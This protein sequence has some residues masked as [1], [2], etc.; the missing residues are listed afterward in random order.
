MA[1]GC[2]CPECWGLAE[3]MERMT[4]KDYGL[5]RSPGHKR[6]RVVE[7]PHL[8]TCDCRVCVAKR[9]ERMDDAQ[10][11]RSIPQPWNP[12]RPRRKAA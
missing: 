5:P 9:Q 6:L 11:V 7:R 3:Y 1:D 10:R 8:M 12:K 2:R 4:G